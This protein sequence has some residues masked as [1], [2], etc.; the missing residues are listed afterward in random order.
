[1]NKQQLLDTMAQVRNSEVDRESAAIRST[2]WLFG[3][4]YS[5]K[6]ESL[7]YE[8]DKDA[9]SP[10]LTSR[11]SATFENCIREAMNGDIVSA[12]RELEDFIINY[13]RDL[14]SELSPFEIFCI[15]QMCKAIH[16]KITKLSL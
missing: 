14:E 4:V 3:Y 1:M 5:K 16:N 11:Q 13:H 8:V 12:F 10:L 9:R 2:D 7:T 15:T 6:R